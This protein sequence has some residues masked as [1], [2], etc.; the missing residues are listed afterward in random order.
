MTWSCLVYLHYKCTLHSLTV[1]VSE[2]FL[3]EEG[4]LFWINSTTLLPQFSVSVPWG[5]VVFIILQGLGSLEFEKKLLTATSNL[6]FNISRDGKSTTSL[7]N[8]FCSVGDSTDTGAWVWIGL[9]FVLSKNLLWK[10]IFI[11][12][13]NQTCVWK[14]GWGKL[15]SWAKEPKFRTRSWPLLSEN[16][17]LYF[18]ALLMSHAGRAGPEIQFEI[19][20][21][22][23][24]SKNSTGIYRKGVDDV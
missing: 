19:L 4:S 1:W 5:C 20:Q 15:S 12:W 6:A 22:E 10:I 17:H 13:Q 24:R 8:L 21:V 2:Y 3:G 18:C 11:A 14:V 16:W 9:Y 23:I 7:V